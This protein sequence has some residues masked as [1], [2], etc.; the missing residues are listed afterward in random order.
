VTKQQ[1]AQQ[2]QKT[3]GEGGA[4]GCLNSSL[5]VLPMDSQLL[6]LS[7]TSSAVLF[8][9]SQDEFNAEYKAHPK[10]WMSTFWASFCPDCKKNTQ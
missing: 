6:L 10:S 5:S 9:K 2:Q 4:A 1:P 8:K 3:G 7:P